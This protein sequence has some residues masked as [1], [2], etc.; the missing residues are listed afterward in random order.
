MGWA[1]RANKRPVCWVTC[2][3][4]GLDRPIQALGVDNPCLF[5]VCQICLYSDLSTLK[6]QIVA[7]GHTPQFLLSD[8]HPRTHP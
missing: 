6:R 5:T 3:C 8:A 4:C 1:E 2:P 7:L